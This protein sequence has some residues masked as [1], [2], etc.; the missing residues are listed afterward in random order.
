MKIDTICVQGGWKPK[1]GE[2]RQPP[3]VAATTF[4]Y[5]TTQ[6]MA[7]LFDLKESGYF[8]TRLQN[9]TNDNVAAKIVELEGGVA[10]M[11]TSSGQAASTYSILNLCSAGD[12]V[13]CSAHI[14]G[15]TYNLFNVSLRK[16]GVEFTF[17]DPDASDEEINNAFRPNTKCM[18]GET[19]ANPSG[20]VLDLERFAKIAH[21]N[22]VPLIVDNTFP[23]P[24]LCRPFE[25]GADIVIHATT[26]Y[27]DGH[28]AQ[29]GGAIIDSGNFDWEKHPEKFACLVDPDPSYHG[30]SY[31]KTFGK[32]AYIV[33]ATA[34]LMRDYGSIAS[35]FNAYILNLGLESLHLRI[36]RHAENAY[37][38]AKWLKTREEVAWVNYSGLEDSPYKALC[39]KQFD[40]GLPS[41]VLTFGIKGG[42]EASIKFMDSLKIVEIV[43]HVADAR[44]CVLHP[45]SHTHRQLTDEQLRAAGIPPDLIRFSAGIEDADDLIADIEQA[46][47]QIK[48]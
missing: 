37:K 43:T 25:F 35:P 20:K 46:L 9:P 1:K 3:I 4:R 14:Y 39:E 47:A 22:G 26:K 6:Q 44:S 36:R 5:E 29:V 15:G 12:H 41:G 27:M 19:V 32:A 38:I 23:T 17:V 21:S 13:V 18:F 16:L 8:Y 7:D 30:L 48:E 40:G 34:Q 42:R 45:A 31:T 28:A 2:P 24:V 10:G 33:K 11:L